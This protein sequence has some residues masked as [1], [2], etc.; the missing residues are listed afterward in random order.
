MPDRLPASTLPRLLERAA[1]DTTRGITFSTFAGGSFLSYAELRDCACRI[2]HGLRGLGTAPG[3]R[4]LIEANDPENF[5]RA[6]WGC[7]LAGAVPCPVAPPADPSRWRAQLEHLRTLLGDPLMV[8]SKAAH[9]DVP[10]VGLRTVTVEE[11]SHA[12]AE[13]DQLHA[14]APDD[15]ALLM[16]TSGSTGSSKAVRLTHANLLAA[17][18]GKAGALELGPDDTSLN[19]ISAD[20]IA[21]I[22]AHLLPMFNGADQ[23]MTVPATVLADPVEFLRLLTA[24]RVRVTFT[25]N[26]LFGQI[27]QALAGRR[28]SPG[29]LDLSRVRHI[30]SGGEATV[31]A[32]VR[33]FLD[34]LS[35]YGLREDVIVPAFGMTET[36]AGSIFNRDF[37]T[38]DLETEFPP[39]GRPVRGLR[40]RITGG[41]GTVLASTDRPASA[42]PGEVQLHGPMVSA[43]YFGNDEATAQAFTPDGW[44]RT[45]D[46]GY[47]DPEGR[48]MLVGRTKD[49]I[50]VSGVNYYSHDLETV[51]DELDGVKR[52]QVAAFPIRPE[53]ADSEQLAVAFVPAGDPADDTAVY[54]AIV[55]IRSST[56]M[57]WGFRPQLILPVAEG[58]IP[59][60]NLNKI[61]R[62][63]LRAAVE[64]GSLDAAARRS[65]EVSTRFLGGYVAPEGDVE[66]ALAG[67]YARVLNTEK[68]PAT[69][70]FFD[71]GGT[72]LDVLRLKLEIQVE[73]GIDELPMS[74]LLQA[75]TVRA[76]AGRLRGGQGADADGD[77]AYDPLV[78][79]QVTGDGTPLFCVHPG[80]GEVLVFINLAKY[81]TGERPFYA[82]RARGFG[83]GE[84]HFGSFADMVSTYVEAIRRVQPSG[85]YAVAG[86]SYGGA[87]A[88]EIAK[89]LEADGDRV[90]FVGVFNLPPHISGRMNEI[91]FTDGAINL[92]LFLELIDAADIEELTATLRPLPEADQ[93]A[94][95]IDH[96]PPR[97]LT[98]VDLTLERFAAWVDLAQSMV[99]LG[100]AYEPSGSVGQV[101]VFYCTPLRGTKQEWLDNQLRHWDEFTRDANTY[102][103]VDGEHYTLMS[104]Q[105]VHTFQ[106]TLRQEL[107]RALG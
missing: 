86:Y 60:G 78:P 19:W 16:L 15:L 51:L 61:Q 26:F 50:I 87:V 96:A 106:A 46:L 83:Q 70:S 76:L 81:F 74:T 13:H 8:V 10:D 100:R 80:L 24:H 94:H 84:T 54:R 77:L 49:S 64:D 79:L 82:L 4:V 1:S 92:A 89:R 91:T 43:G 12:P 67:I 5:F 34:A 9:G 52:G 25:P 101:K 71:L 27:N 99:H 59:R 97:R 20:H 85:P 23:V 38:Q 45:G 88:F 14:P 90:D 35:P 36:C 63:R 11:L 72:S 2:S 93:L 30:I 102:I 6:F 3:D 66:I 104:P 56:V 73:F 105:H 48:L 53:G 39:L 37:A 98:E 58:E 107:A 33:N 103:E 22:E 7:V 41:D 47:L 68:V 32:T 31:T 62:S 65:D 18:A 28:P 21:A 75:P 95:L 55:A 69:A 44:F 17:Q 57:H 29:E 42:E 40:I